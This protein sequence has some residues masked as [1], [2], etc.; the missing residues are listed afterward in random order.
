MFF[1]QTLKASRISP[2]DPRYLCPYRMLSSRLSFLAQNLRYGLQDVNEVNYLICDQD[3]NP[4]HVLRDLVLSVTDSFSNTFNIFI[5]AAE[6]A[7][8]IV[9]SLQ[10]DG[11]SMWEAAMFPI[12]RQFLQDLLPTICFNAFHDSSIYSVFILLP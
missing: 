7:P 5:C 12:H 2:L 10:G 6:L 1:P 3:A 8:V 4:P 9:P 11:C